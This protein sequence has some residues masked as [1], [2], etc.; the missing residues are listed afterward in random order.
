[1]NI[2][3]PSRSRAVTA[4]RIVFSKFP[5][6]GGQTEAPAALSLFRAT[7]GLP[8]ANAKASSAAAPK[9]FLEALRSAMRPKKDRA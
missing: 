3:T 8:L 2:K 1:M 5:W 6:R 9:A 7:R 4:D